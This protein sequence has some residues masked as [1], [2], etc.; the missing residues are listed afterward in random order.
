[1]VGATER[2][3]Y[4]LGVLALPVAF[5]SYVNGK[6]ETYYPYLTREQLPTSLAQ[7]PTTSI[8][9]KINFTQGFYVDIPKAWFTSK[10]NR[11]EEF[12]QILFNS[13]FPHRIEA[14]WLSFWNAV[15]MPKFKQFGDIPSFVSGKYTLLENN[16]KD[17]RMQFAF[18]AVPGWLSRNLIVGGVHTL[19]V[20]QTDRQS[21]RVWFVSHLAL[22]S[23][24]LEDVQVDGAAPHPVFGSVPRF[25][26]AATGTV[27]GPVSTAQIQASRF[28]W[29]CVIDSTLQRMMRMRPLIQF[30]EE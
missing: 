1:M 3:V 25:V 23:Q 4:R 28:F 24:S 7:P 26:D 5:I 20:E 8:N 21:V 13:L 15:G 10:T 12:A 30:F 9:K 19:Y 18:E 16:G 11:E 27:L 2:L 17:S 22:K 6:M 29:R 14:M